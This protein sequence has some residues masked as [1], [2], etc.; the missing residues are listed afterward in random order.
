MVSLGIVA[1][2]KLF[3]SE[4]R[5]RTKNTRVHRTTARVRATRDTF[6]RFR[7]RTRQARKHANTCRHRRTVPQCR[8]AP[9]H[10]FGI[11]RVIVAS[12]AHR[13]NS[14]PGSWPTPEAPLRADEAR[15][16]DE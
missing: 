2:Y 16:P 4:K 6:V 11:A 13:S 14:P 7:S 1:C 3:S 8:S 15:R 10:R 12:Q 9:L 5:D